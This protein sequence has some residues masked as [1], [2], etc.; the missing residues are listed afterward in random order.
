MK[1][2]YLVSGSIETVKEVRRGTKDHFGDVLI[3]AIVVFDSP[4]FGRCWDVVENFEA[5]KP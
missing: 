5:P 3:P 2:K 1:L 4:G